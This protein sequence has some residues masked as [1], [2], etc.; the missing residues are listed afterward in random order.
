MGEIL[1]MTRVMKNVAGLMAT[2]LL[3][4]ACGTPDDEAQ[5]TIVGQLP[6][7]A[8]QKEQLGLLL[9]KNSPLTSCV[10]QAV[11][12]LRADGT[13]ASLQDQWLAQQGA[14]VLGS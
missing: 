8:D 13:L 14:P 7:T 4:A 1:A 5:G 3:L 10:T 9:A 11:D 12:A 2:A 6:N